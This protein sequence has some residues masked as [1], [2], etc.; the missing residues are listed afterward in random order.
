MLPVDEGR[1]GKHS[2]RSKRSLPCQKVWADGAA[3]AARAFNCLQRR[4]P[5]WPRQCHFRS[6]R[7]W[8]SRGG[9][10][11]RLVLDSGEDNW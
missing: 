9:N 4:D 11:K 6:K 8:C 3:A 1:E 2:A 10:R 5:F 7:Q